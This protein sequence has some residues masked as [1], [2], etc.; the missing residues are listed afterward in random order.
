M[1]PCYR[2]AI[3]VLSGTPIALSGSG[4][5]SD[6]QRDYLLAE[7]QVLFRVD[8]KLLKGLDSKLGS[9]GFATR[10]AWFKQ[11]IGDYTGIKVAA[12]KAAKKAAPKKAAKKTAK[13]APKKAAKKATKKAAKKATKKTAKKATKKAAKKATKKA[14]KKGPKKAAKKAAKKTARRRRR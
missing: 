6:G 13:K 14:T 10:N 7:K 8:A 2:S 12:P 3:R 5:D 4:I 11:A 1:W 9:D